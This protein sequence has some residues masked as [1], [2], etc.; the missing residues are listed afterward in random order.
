MSRVRSAAPYVALGCA[1]VS[2][3]LTA[4]SCGLAVMV[5][6]YREF[7]VPLTLIFGLA[8]LAGGSF[9]LV[10]LSRR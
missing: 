1:V 2:I 9:A 3:L 10:R 7:T 4:T 8:A 6:E 5:R